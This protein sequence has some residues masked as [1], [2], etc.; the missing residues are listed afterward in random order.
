MPETSGASVQ[1]RVSPSVSEPEAGWAGAG[2]APF[3]ISKSEGGCLVYGES[4]LGAYG[5]GRAHYL[6]AEAG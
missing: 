1:R 2:M 4:V 5:G 6:D 3:H